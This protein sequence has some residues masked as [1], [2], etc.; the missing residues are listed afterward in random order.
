MNLSKVNSRLS[1]LSEEYAKK[2]SGKDPVGASKRM[3]G[4]MVKQ[5]KKDNI[6]VSDVLPT[7]AWGLTPM[8]LTIGGK[9]YPF[10]V[11]VQEFPNGK[12][13]FSVQL[14]TPISDRDYSIYVMDGAY[15]GMGKVEGKFG[16]Y[17]KA[18][19]SML[20]S[21]WPQLWVDLKDDVQFERLLPLA[22]VLAK[23]IAKGIK[24]MSESTNDL[25]ESKP[26]SKGK[27]I[28]FAE[29]DGP[30]STG[31]GGRGDFER[32]EYVVGYYDSQD[33]EIGGKSFRNYRQALAHLNKLAKAGVETSSLTG[34]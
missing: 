2:V 20:K 7:N 28:S 16:K 27:I 29:L 11:S 10:H 9:R 31:P 8:I 19:V 6:K 34:G 15:E 32:G 21:D 17:G 12:S 30:F 25:H 5:F 33:N 23:S 13:N 22:S 14:Q 26:K 3:A 1:A 24:S 4:L 18:K